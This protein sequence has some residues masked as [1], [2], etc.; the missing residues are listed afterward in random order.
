MEKFI[1]TKLA[2]WQLPIKMQIQHYI[3][4]AK[5]S[6]HNL[7]R[8]EAKKM[9]NESKKQEIWINDKY[10]VNILRGK[11]CDQY[12][13]IEEYK[14]KCDYISIKTLDKEPIH[15]WRD[16]QQI[17]NELCGEDREALEIYPMEERLVDT[18]NQYH[19]WVLPKNA[20]VPFGFMER[21]VNYKEQEGDFN[22]IGQR[23]KDEN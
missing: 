11:D 2:T 7:P 1:R 12:V 4:I 20:G 21:E 16:F 19:L 18:A 9:V 8:E 14:G 3:D 15:D 22:S 17:K 5:E 23:G 6:G 13:H 10:Q